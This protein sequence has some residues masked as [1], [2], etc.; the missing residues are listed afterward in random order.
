MAWFATAA[1]GLPLHLNGGVHQIRDLIHVDDIATATVRALIAP[2]AH[3]E[4]I[5]I[6]TGTPTSIRTVAELVAEQYP[7]TRFVETPM[8]PGDPLGGYATTHRMEAVLGWRPTITVKDGVAR[9]TAWLA[10]VPEAIPA[11]LRSRGR[12]RDRLIR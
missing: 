3:N 6:G 10:K 9:Y 2:R 12:G 1:L 5:N 8:P 11:W 4:T 7:Q